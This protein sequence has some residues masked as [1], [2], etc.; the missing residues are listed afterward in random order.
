M[1]AAYD[2]DPYDGEALM[3]GEENQQGSKPNARG[4]LS[5]ILILG[6]V[7]CN[8]LS[9]GG[10]GLFVSLNSSGGDDSPSQAAQASKTTPSADFESSE[11]T[12]NGDGANESDAE[13]EGMSGPAADLG[14]TV[15]LGTFVINLNDPGHPRYLKVTL[16]AEVSGSGTKNEIRARE[17][18]VRDLIISYLSSLAIKETYG[19]RAKATIRDNIQRRLNHVLTT[20]EVTQVFFTDF[21]TQ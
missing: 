2:F 15:K 20:G 1:V 8:V 9:L 7:L 12:P 19:A 6:L 4:G 14:P 3:A 16:K 17:P 21:M 13:S 18:Q 11:D 10:L 5:K